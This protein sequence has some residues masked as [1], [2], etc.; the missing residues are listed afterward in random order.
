M[1]TVCGKCNGTEFYVTTEQ[2]VRGM[3]WMA[4]GQAVKV[5]KCKKC[6]VNMIVE[7]DKTPKEIAKIWVITLVGIFVG[8]IV[9]TFIFVVL[10]DAGLF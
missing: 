4:R 9:M 1:K 10:A 8:L 2:A 5:K 6:D 3:G 7:Q